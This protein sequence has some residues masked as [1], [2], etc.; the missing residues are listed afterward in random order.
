MPTCRAFCGKC[1][2]TARYAAW[3]FAASINAAAA[4][5]G[6][7]SSINS[8]ADIA[9]G[10]VFDLLVGD[11]GEENVRRLMR[12]GGGGGGGGGVER[13]NGR[14]DRGKNAGEGT[15]AKGRR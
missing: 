11:E 3:R 13:G 4:A 7:A 10:G 15:C 6:F 2:S 5:R 12:R 14:N 1:S 8:A 9:A